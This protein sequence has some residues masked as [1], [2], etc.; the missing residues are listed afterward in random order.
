MKIIKPTSTDQTPEGVC[1]FLAGSIEMGAAE[2]WQK[3]VQINFEKEE[4]TFFNPRRDEW[5]ASWKQEQTNPMFNNQVNWELNHL[6]SADLI[7]MYFSP[8]T[9]SP[10]SLLELGLY[11]DSRKMI[12]C[13]PE[14]FW[15]KG[16]VEILCT[17]SNVP[18]YTDLAQ[19][20][21]ALRTRLHQEKN[22]NNSW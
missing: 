9:K 13:C 3:T 21:G 2:D 18:F 17:R 4:V 19:A 7:F 14:G 12:V 6:E 22:V 16:N 11:A 20:I 5:D 1:V 15:R 10:I 8:E